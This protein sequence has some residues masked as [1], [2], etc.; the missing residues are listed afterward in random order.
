MKKS[1]RIYLASICIAALCSM[2]TPLVAWS[3]SVT[4]ANTD[5]SSYEEVS[6]KKATN[7]MFA[8]DYANKKVRFKITF[9][10][11]M[12]TTMD[13]PREYREGYVRIMGS[14]AGDPYTVSGN[15]LVPKEI[16]DPIFELTR[17][18]NIELFGT[19]KPMI[20]TSSI[21]HQS[22][23]FLLMVI[24]K[25]VTLKTE[26]EVSTIPDGAYVKDGNKKCYIVLREDGTFHQ[27]EP[28][29]EIEGTYRI[30]G[31]K[32][33]WV[34]N[35]HSTTDKYY[36]ELI[37]DARTDATYVKTANQNQPSAK[38]P[39]VSANCPPAGSKVPFAKVM[40][41]AFAKDYAGCNIVMRAKFGASGADANAV[42]ITS[43]AT[44]EGK[45]VFRL[46]GPG[47]KSVDKGAFNVLIGKAQ[48][49][50]VF[51]LEEGTSIDVTGGTRFLTETDK[52]LVFEARKIQS[53]KK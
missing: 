38:K 49:D 39:T 50:I 22:E 8:D 10:G 21:S 25:V 5:E 41:P 23:K 26:T 14:A 43:K 46:L 45:V 12:P 37:V 28:A 20:R 32:I 53:V 48:S 40:N 3:R 19:L 33:T 11:I 29:G 30:D 15:F 47:A 27:W 6:L 36:G 31:D 18:N 44:K 34:A 4:P 42:S 9:A 24:D 2:T 16:S 51:E 13:L 1:L 7:P 52:D 17:K 35:G